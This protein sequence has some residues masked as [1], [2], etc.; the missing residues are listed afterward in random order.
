MVGRKVLLRVDKGPARPGA[1]VLE[2]DHLVVRDAAGVARVKDISF[3]VRAG[4]IV[5]IAG[6]AGNGQSELLEA[7]AGIRPIAGGR[8]AIKGRPVSAVAHARTQ[9]LGH[10]PED[11]LR[12][13]LVPE[14][15]AYENAI[16]GLP[17]R[18]GVQRPR[19]PRQGRDHRHLPALDARLRRT[20]RRCALEGA[21]VLRRQSA[22]ARARARAGARSRPAAGRAADPRGRHRRDRVHPQAPD[23]HARRRQGGAPRFGRAGRDHVARPIASW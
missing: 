11:R 14:F 5:G 6:V 18:S 22:E 16:L 19:P 4:E 10:V 21:L 9:G 1:P 12:M 3:T 20:P 7:L 15:A 17:A 23:R 2:V 13:G 8:I